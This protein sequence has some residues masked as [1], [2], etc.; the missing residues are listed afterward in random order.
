MTDAMPGLISPPLWTALQTPVGALVWTAGLVAG[1]GWM[2]RELWARDDLGGRGR[3]AW[4]LTVGFAGPIGWIAYLLA[5]LP[6]AADGALRRAV[7][8]TV[9]T[10][11]GLAP[12]ACLGLALTR[13]L[14]D[15]GPGL[16]AGLAAALASVGGVL[17]ARPP[18]RRGSG[19]LAATAERET[20][21]VVVM[22]AWALGAWTWRLG[23]EAP[24]GA[25]GA[26]A[27][28]ASLV[29]ALL[30]GILV[31]LVRV[32]AGVRGDGEA[33]ERAAAG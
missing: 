9:P 8:A 30:L 20:A 1:L 27:G 19:A 7:R 22:C 15:L 4:L 10:F 2:H 28:V 21:A 5:G 12:V 18:G 33:L 14:V 24:E 31:N 6:R 29:E 25:R 32:H 17:L 13:G 11:G 26:A 3:A 16:G 23:L